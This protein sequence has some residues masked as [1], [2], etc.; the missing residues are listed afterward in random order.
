MDKEE[1]FKELLS[2]NLST[3]YIAAHPKFALGYG[4]IRTLPLSPETFAV[5][6]MWKYK[7]VKEMLYKLSKVLPVEEAERRIA[8]LV[9]PGF[10]GIPNFQG[11]A[12]LPTL[13]ASFQLV[14]PG[15]IAPAH[16][17]TPNAFRFVIEAPEDGAFTV[18]NGKKLRMRKYDLILTPA[19]TWH[20]HRNESNSEVIWLDGLDLPI[21]SLIG[22]SFFEEY[23]EKYQDIRENEE[24]VVYSYGFNLIPDI[25]EHELFNPLL[26]YPYSKAKEVLIRINEKLREFPP[27]GVTLRY[28][29]PVNKGEVF[30]T[31]SLRLRLIRGKER[32]KLIRET[33]NKVLVQLEGYTTAIVYDKDNRMKFRL[34]PHDVLAIPSWKKYELINEDKEDSIL[35]QF[36]DEPIFRAIGVYKKEIE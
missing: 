16:R 18:V 15:E 20:D 10:K 4:L 31:M 23:K 9:N 28:N 8:L 19:M 34:E 5:P 3:F 25:R 33:E 22:A 32:T 6:Y 35:F 27:E 26:Y 14:L 30:Q 2:K 21:F 12:I 17:H 13:T 24:D 29:N 1:V 36:S 11:Y 7:E